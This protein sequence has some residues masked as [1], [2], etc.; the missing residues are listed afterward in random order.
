MERGKAWGTLSFPQN[1]S[2]ALADR[3][4]AGL[5][6]ESWNIESAD[7][8]VRLDMSGKIFLTFLKILFLI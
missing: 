2:D 5:S 3:A 4:E 8:N 6:A 1:F 7:I